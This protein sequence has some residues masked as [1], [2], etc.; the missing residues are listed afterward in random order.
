[1]HTRILPLLQRFPVTIGSNVTRFFL[2][3]QLYEIHAWVV[4]FHF[5]CVDCGTLRVRKQTCSILISRNMH[6]RR[7]SNVHPLRCKQNKGKFL[8][9]EPRE[10]LEIKQ[11]PKHRQLRYHPPG[12]VFKNST[13]VRTMQLLHT[14]PA[15]AI[16]V[17]DNSSRDTNI[18]N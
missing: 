17:A 1:M 11:G 14:L 3:N 2:C 18:T 10:D 13:V 16:I 4:H 12:L 8:Q 6:L 15:Y 5:K 7:C 9:Q